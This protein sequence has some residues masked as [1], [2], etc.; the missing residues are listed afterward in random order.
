MFTALR[1]CTCD[2]YIS[3]CEGAVLDS[4]LWDDGWDDTSTM[5]EFDTERFPRGFEA[6][7][8]EAK[9]YGAG[10][11]VWLSPWGGYS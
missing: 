8:T 11:G 5:W 3:C 4:F 9:K 10:T 1:V 7:A 2:A 6:V